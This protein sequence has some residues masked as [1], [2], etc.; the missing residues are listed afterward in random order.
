MLPRN[1]RTR[2]ERLEAR[3]R[4]DAPPQLVLL[5]FRKPGGATAVRG[6]DGRRVWWNPPEGHK[7]G[8]FLDEIP[9][10]KIFI[11]GTYTRGGPDAE[12]T[13]AVGP[14]GRLVWLD[15]PEGCKAGEP[16][17]DSAMEMSGSEVVRARAA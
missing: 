3:E 6:P 15:P 11:I 1:F 7:A 17:E 9:A 16:I 2:L 4:D 10:G 12:P 13:A 5:N 14:D 8:G